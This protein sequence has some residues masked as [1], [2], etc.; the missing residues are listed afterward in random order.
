MLVDGRVLSAAD[1][2]RWT[3]RYDPSLRATW[4]ELELSKLNYE[5]FARVGHFGGC[6]PWET[7]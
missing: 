4:E 3:R 6:A 7:P 5:N 2:A 1:V